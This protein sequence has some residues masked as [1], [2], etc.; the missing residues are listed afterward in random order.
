MTSCAF[1]LHRQFVLL[2]YFKNSV[3]RFMTGLAQNID[4]EVFV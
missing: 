3:L 1:N 2:N 4:K